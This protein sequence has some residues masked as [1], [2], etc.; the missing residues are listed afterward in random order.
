M[1]P[2]TARAANSVPQPCRLDCGKP[3]RAPFLRLEICVSPELWIEGRFVPYPFQNNI[4][5]L[6]APTRWRCLQVLIR[7]YKHTPGRRPENFRQWIDA[8]F[9]DG[10]AEAFMIP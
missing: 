2:S 8:T 3:P 7:L 6:T 4:R 10:I 5:H 1:H 9:G